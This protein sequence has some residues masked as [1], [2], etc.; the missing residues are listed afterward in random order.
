MAALPAATVAFFRKTL[1]TYKCPASYSL[2]AK[3]EFFINIKK[4]LECPL[5]PCFSQLRQE[6][7][8]RFVFCDGQLW[9]I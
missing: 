8:A 5:C 6:D 7:G 2:P 1:L 3:E 4:A 9:Y